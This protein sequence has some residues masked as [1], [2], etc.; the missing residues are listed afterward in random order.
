[1]LRTI[2]DYRIQIAPL[3]L[4]KTILDPRFFGTEAALVAVEAIATVN[5]S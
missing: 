3:V 4:S 2:Q 1:M 5:Y